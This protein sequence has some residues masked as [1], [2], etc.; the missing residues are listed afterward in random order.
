MRRAG[1]GAKGLRAAFAVSPTVTGPGGGAKGLCDAVSA[2]PRVPGPGCDGHDMAAPVGAPVSKKKCN[3]A[4]ASG[5]AQRRCGGRRRP[6]RQM[7]LVCA[8]RITC[9]NLLLMA[10]LVRGSGEEI[11]LDGNVVSIGAVDCDILVPVRRM[12]GRASPSRLQ[13]A[14]VDGRHALVERVE[15]DRYI[16]RDMHTQSGTFINDTRM[17]RDGSVPLQHGDI[18]RFGREA[19]VPHCA[20]A[21][22]NSRPCGRRCSFSM[23]SGGTSG[24]PLGRCGG[25]ARRRR[26]GRCRS[27]AHTRHCGLRRCGSV[28]LGSA[29]FAGRVASRIC[30]ES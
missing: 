12:H 25:W 1:G 24:R 17:R 27:C 8:P 14:T 10:T 15:E 7:R 21:A 13:G 29:T 26:A 2:S 11:P 5:E 18:I 16:L 28:R 9:R 6:A 30:K 4:T 19:E 22:I 3:T 20:G 23:R